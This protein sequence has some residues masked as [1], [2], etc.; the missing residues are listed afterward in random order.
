MYFNDKT[1]F[2]LIN[3]LIYSRRPCVLSTP[4]PTDARAPLRETELP[5]AEGKTA[6]GGSAA[7][8]APLRPRRPRSSPAPPTALLCTPASDGSS[9]P[10]H[11]S[12]GRPQCESVS[13]LPCSPC[14]VPEAP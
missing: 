9:P 2:R 3:Y 6:L 10:A 7:G 5:L 13:S 1:D 4:V 14:C 12:R 11:P 8:R